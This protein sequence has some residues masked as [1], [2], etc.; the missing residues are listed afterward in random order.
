MRRHLL[1]AL[2][3]CTL[4]GCSESAD[5]AVVVDQGAD[6]TTVVVPASVRLIVRLTDWGDGGFDSWELTTLP[7]PAVLELRRYTHEPPEAQMPG[8]FGADV[9]E[10]VAVAPGSTSL[11]ASA[12]QPWVGGE[13]ITFTLGVDVE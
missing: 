12:S 6:G 10:L 8:D 13:T 5:P 2:V 9:F 1:G 11:V 7:D 4:A 3:A